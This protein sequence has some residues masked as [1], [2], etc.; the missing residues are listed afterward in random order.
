MNLRTQ[1]SEDLKQA[2]RNRE[3]V[4]M[5]TIR[6]VRAAILNRE[7]EVGREVD[8]DEILRLIRGL[9]KQ[10]IDSAEQYTA[11]GRQDLADRELQEQRILET[12]LP[13][14]P[15]AATVERTVR[16]TI[17]D[18]GATSMKDMGKVMKACQQQLGPAVDGKSLSQLIKSALQGG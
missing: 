15:D 1:L 17:A 10:R 4:A 9:I 7:V 2:M 8:D 6:G 13:P 5:E 18:L 12:Y 11:G 14:A 3:T 16:A